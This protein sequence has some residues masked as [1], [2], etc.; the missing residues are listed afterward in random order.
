METEPVNSMGE[1]S[2]VVRWRERIRVL[3]ICFSSYLGGGILLFYWPGWLHHRSLPDILVW[4][5][6][7]GIWLCIWF[8]VL[9]PRWFDKARKNARPRGLRSEERRVGK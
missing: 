2:Q 1:S 4:S 3:A 7:Y 8:S 5:L 6:I 9:R